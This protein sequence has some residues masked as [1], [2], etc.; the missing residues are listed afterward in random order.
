MATPS[1]GLRPWAGRALGLVGAGAAVVDLATRPPSPAAS[2]VLLLTGVALATLDLGPGKGTGPATGAPDRVGRPFTPADL[3]GPAAAVVAVAALLDHGYAWAG[4]PRLAPL[5]AMP[6]GAA[7]LLAA[8]AAAAVLARPDRGLPGRL[9]GSAPSAIL[10]RR[11]APLAGLP[12]GAVAIGALVRSAGGGPT[13]AVTVGTALSAVVVVTVLVRAGQDLD[14]AD[15]RRVLRIAA[16]REERDFADTL[17]RSM[18]ESVIVLDPDLRVIEANQQ[19]YELIGRSRDQVIGQTPPYPWQPPTPDALTPNPSVP[20][21]VRA[22]PTTSACSGPMAPWCRCSPP[23]P[24]SPDRTGGRAPTWRPI[25][26][27]P[28]RS[29]PATSWRS[30]PCCSSGSTNTCAAPTSGSSRRPDSPAT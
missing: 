9:S 4:L 1:R 25:W 17:L 27:S 3:I 7:I 19:W 21:P 23:G 26:T 18:A 20:A 15:G 30:R 28:R 8:L 5:A 10:F 12:V 14:R 22:R 11:L 16:L 6:V 29:G 24:R 2:L 13:I